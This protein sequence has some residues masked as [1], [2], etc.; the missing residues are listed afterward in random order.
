MSVVIRRAV[1]SDA[2]ALALVGGATFLETYSEILPGAALV[3]HCAAQHRAEV[4]A[5]WLADPACAV[6][7]AEAALGAPAGYLVMVP[8]TL[9][10]GAVVAGD[11]EVLRVYVLAPYYG[12][13]LGFRLMGAAVAEAR[14]RGAGRV[15]L[16][17]NN[18]NERALGF[19]RRQGFGAIGAREFLVGGAVCSDTVLGLV[20]R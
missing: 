19:Y 14:S 11:L 9:P 17:M 1:A 8:A 16:G 20:L 6:W 7:I 5:G 13:G 18:Q 12:T 3:A 15:V 4:Y 2:T 10:I